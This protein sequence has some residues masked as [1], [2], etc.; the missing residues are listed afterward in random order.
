MGSL[1]ENPQV[2]HSLHYYLANFALLLWQ[3]E[4]PYADYDR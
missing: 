3:V 1:R 2:F 4:P